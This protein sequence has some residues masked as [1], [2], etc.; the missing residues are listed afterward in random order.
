MR[1]RIA[2]I[3]LASTLL[4]VGCVPAVEPTRTA[5]QPTT[6]TISESI[7]YPGVDGTTLENLAGSFEMTFSGEEEWTYKLNIHADEGQREYDLQ[8]EG[9][10]PAQ[11]PGDVRIVVDE[12]TIRMRGPGTDGECFQFPRDLEPELNLILPDDVMAPENVEPLTLIEEGEPIAG[13]TTVHYATTQIDSARWDTLQLDL[14]RSKESQRILRLDFQV[15]GRDP[16][17]AAGD[18]T[19][20][21]RFTVQELGNQI[22][23]PIQ[24][25]E[26]PYPLPEDATRV[27]NLPGMIAFQSERSV[28]DLAQFYPSAL[29]DQGWSPMGEPEETASG[30]LLSFRREGE[31]LDV[32]VESLDARSQVEIIPG[33]E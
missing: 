27:T 11:D 26:I 12:Q 32:N 25:C 13:V 33:E 22:I 10:G 23:L 4:I 8:M 7:P 20:T 15:T 9:L 21:G 17:F 5:E 1:R 18:G 19:L 3:L 16:F 14:W 31:T 24:G 2:A 28:D 29:A 6:P 30:V